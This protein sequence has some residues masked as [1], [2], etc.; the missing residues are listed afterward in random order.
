M[1]TINLVFCEH[2]GSHLLLFSTHP[3]QLYVEIIDL[4]Y[5]FLVVTIEM[6]TLYNKLYLNGCN[7]D[8]LLTPVDCAT[9]LYYLFG[10]DL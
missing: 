4:Y 9:V 2:F 7:H 1:E 6:Y 5:S 10:V 3:R 8:Y